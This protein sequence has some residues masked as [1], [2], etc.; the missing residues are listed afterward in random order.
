MC[1]KINLIIIKCDHA[2]IHIRSFC[3]FNNIEITVFSLAVNVRVKTL[4]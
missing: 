1:V 2:H 4:V 3:Q